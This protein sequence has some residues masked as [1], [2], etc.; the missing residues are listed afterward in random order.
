MG[1][2]NYKVAMRK[3]LIVV[4]SFVDPDR[5]LK[6]YDEHSDVL[7]LTPGAMVSI[8]ALKI[9]YKTTDDFYSTEL[10]KTDLERL[11]RR[12]EE[13]LSELDR[14][15]EGLIVA[16]GAY[17][18]SIFYFF[19]VFANLLY[20]E[21]I[22]Q[23]LT[24]NYGKVYFFTGS[25][26]KNL[27]WG[28]LTY[29]QLRSIPQT[30][31]LENKVQ[32]LRKF[33]NVE[34]VAADSQTAMRI[35]RVRKAAV[36]LKRLPVR[37]KKGIREN[38]FSFLQGQSIFFAFMK[39]KILFV[40][41]DGYEVG[42]LRKHMPDFRFINSVSRLRKDILLLPTQNYDFSRIKLKLKDFLETNFPK[43]NRLIE[44]L[45]LS[46]HREVVGRLGYFKESF[47]KLIE[48]SKPRALIFSVGTR[49]SVDSI[50][51]HVANEKKIPVIYFQ[52]GGANLFIRNLFLRYV[53]RDTKAIK[54]LI[55]NSRIEKELAEHEGSRCVALGS[56]MRY[57]LIQGVRNCVNHRAIY[58]CGPIPFY[59]YN[60]I[61]HRGSDKQCYKV[62]REI[63]EATRD[64]SVRLDVKLHPIEEDFCFHYFRRLID[65]IGYMKSRVIYGQIAEDIIKNYDLIVF[66]FI[67]T[68]VFPLA[69]SLKVPIILYL[70]DLSLINDVVMQDLKN[71]CY[72]V[73]E[74]NELRVLFKRYVSGDL[75]SK[76]SLDIVDR[77]VYPVKNG[78]PGPNIANYI[79]SVCMD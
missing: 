16:S 8:D 59:N 56:I 15:C 68:A 44:D 41:Q 73:H 7:A 11:Y 26:V 65:D 32:I 62:N 72:I 5:F 29:K 33:L 27:F 2:L 38:R 49:D 77:Y 75:P 4:P 74:K 34:E 23:K 35:S 25:R 54:T 76:W 71:R 63:L 3:N 64:E 30:Q 46:Y 10:F 47:E 6:L 55:L 14:I 28:T 57:Q 66:D 67:G 21:R 51:A 9:P 45:F 24:A 53:E 17:T 43:S 40:I 37:F 36:Y 52:H 22:S 13:I 78:H 39:K 61:L 18:G 12:A 31:G 79:R 60:T 19:M 58:C 70:K 50:F 42:F 48:A 69:I 20:L 1:R